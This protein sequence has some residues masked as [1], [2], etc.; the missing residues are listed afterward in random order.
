MAEGVNDLGSYTCGNFGLKI[1]NAAIS[2]EKTIALNTSAVT[3]VLV[4]AEL[5]SFIPGVLLSDLPVG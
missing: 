4:D 2:A 1:V 3:N 5:A